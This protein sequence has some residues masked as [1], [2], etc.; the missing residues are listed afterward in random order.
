MRRQP[1]RAAFGAGTAAFADANLYRPRLVHSPP[2]AL[3]GLGAPQ[4]VRVTVGDPGQALVAGI[5]E[6]L[7]G[8]LTEFV[9]GGSREVAM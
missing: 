1:V 4:V 8:T 7:P 5:A 9:R 6:N 2:A 3:I